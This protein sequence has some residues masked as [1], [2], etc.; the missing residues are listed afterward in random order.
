M[1]QSKNLHLKHEGFSN[2]FWRAA[3]R[4]KQD[5]SSRSVSTTIS[6]T[7]KITAAIFTTSSR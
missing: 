3:Y 1:S 5:R 2:C 6:T 7:G 4:R